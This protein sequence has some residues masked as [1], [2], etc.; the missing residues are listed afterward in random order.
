MG[1]CSAK[2][3]QANSLLHHMFQSGVNIAGTAAYQLP[4]AICVLGHI[5]Y[6]LPLL[7]GVAPTHKEY[8]LG[9]KQ[10][11]TGL[12]GFPRDLLPTEPEP[13]SKS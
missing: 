11:H 12:N 5:F 1:L 8:K 2:P 7:V 3:S 4:P 10:G 13:A 9:A 6:T